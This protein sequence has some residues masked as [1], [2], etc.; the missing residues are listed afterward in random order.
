MNSSWSTA[1]IRSL[2]VS[3]TL[4][5]STQPS[6]HVHRSLLNFL[7]RPPLHW[8]PHFVSRRSYQ[9][10][11]L[12]NS[13]TR[14]RRRCQSSSKVASVGLE[15]YIPTAPMSRCPLAPPPATLTTTIRFDVFTYVAFHVERL[16][17][18]RAGE[19]RRARESSTECARTPG[20]VRHLY[21]GLR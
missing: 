6:R 10:S 9:T 13:P 8:E 14:T 4:S 18:N 16:E 15:P 12:P 20:I 19:A 21:Q 7:L 1:C 11:T 2:P 5:W 17:D 3:R